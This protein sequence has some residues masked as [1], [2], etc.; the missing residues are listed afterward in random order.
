[1]L[2]ESEV[3]I[4]VE[5]G[6]TTRQ[7]RIFL[8]LLKYKTQS[9]KNLSITSKLARQ[10]T[11]K[12]LDELQE[13][14]IVE[15]QIS[16]PTKFAAINVQ[17]ALTIMLDH[18]L[19]QT[20]DLETKTRL[21]IKSL[22]NQDARTTENEEPNLFL[23]PKGET[24]SFKLRKAVDMTKKSVDIVSSGRNFPQGLFFLT[25][26]LVRA[27]GRGVKIRCLTDTLEDN[28]S[29]SKKLHA[30]Q[31]NPFFEVRTIQT[32]SKPRF[33]IYDKKELSVVLSSEKD[34]AKSSLLW[35]TCPSIVETYQDHFDMMWHNATTN[36]LSKKREIVQA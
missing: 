3:Q 15:K 18:K 12:V 24:L 14:G 36:S 11:Y 23:V 4:L 22:K 17:D 25:E 10:D 28:D 5:L 9:A 30:L 7:A 6:L 13:F 29:R 34:F 35:S 1:M 27:I 8:S 33:C 32:N 21:L 2:E 20:S 16:N 31:G 26:E 19:Q